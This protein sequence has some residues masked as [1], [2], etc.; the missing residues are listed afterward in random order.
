MDISHSNSRPLRETSVPFSYTVNDIRSWGD[1]ASF[2]A[3]LRAVNRGDVLNADYDAKTQIGSGVVSANGNL[4]NASFQLCNWKYCNAENRCSCQIGQ[5]GSMCFHTLAIAIKL[6]RLYEAKTGADRKSADSNL[7]TEIDL[8][9][10]TVLRDAKNGEPVSLVFVLPKN[11]TELMN[12]HKSVLLGIYLTPRLASPKSSPTAIIHIEKAI[13]LKRSLSLEHED[14][15]ML[16]LLEEMAEGSLTGE[17]RVNPSSLL[18]LL[19]YLGN[20]GRPIYQSD[21][22]DSPTKNKERHVVKSIQET[23]PIRIRTEADACETFI[24]CSFNPCLR[25]IDASIHADIPGAIPP[26]EITYI[27]P[28]GEKG[29]AMIHSTAETSGYAFELIP[30]KSILPIVFRQFYIKPIRIDPLHV[31]RFLKYERNTLQNSLPVK[32]DPEVESLSLTPLSPQFLLEV[33]IP[34][35]ETP[36][37]NGWRPSPGNLPNRLSICLKACYEP[38]PGKQ[39]AQTVVAGFPG[40]YFSI[41]D[42]NDSYHYFI[43]D[44]A[45]EQKG[46]EMLRSFEIPG[47]TDEHAATLLLEG[48]D[49]VLHFL[50]TTAP[51]IEAL[52]GWSVDFSPT[53]ALHKLV[54]SFERIGIEVKI[55][56]SNGDLPSVFSLTVAYKTVGRRHYV[57]EKEILE[58]AAENRTYLI[59]Y[60]PHKKEPRQRPVQPKIQI[61][62]SGIIQAFRDLEQECHAFRNPL[63]KAQTM[64]N[65]FAPFVV[66]RIR[67]L[68][69]SGVTFDTNASAWV[70]KY[71]RPFE[72]SESAKD[73]Q[74]IRRLLPRVLRP[75]QLEGVLWLRWLE[76]NNFGG[77]LADEMG[78]GKTLQALAWISMRRIY[79]P[80]TKRPV[81]VV[82]PTS[83][84]RNW[85]SEAHRFVPQLKTLVLS[86]TDR[87]DV[88]RLIPECDLVITS[89]ALLRR[90]VELYNTVLFSA[91]LL[92]EAQNIKNRDTD[93]ATSVKQIR[94]RTRIAITGTPIE[95]SLADLW[96]IF[97]FLMPGYLG[98]Y[99]EFHTRFEIPIGLRHSEAANPTD[100]READILLSKLR[101]KTAPFLLRRLKTTV[102]QDL[103]EKLEQIVPTE[104]TADQQKVYRSLQEQIGRKI[105]DSVS[106]NGF[107][108]SRMLILS[109]LLRLRQAAC[110]LSLLGNLNPYPN[111]EHPSGKLSQMLSILENTIASGHRVLIFSQFVEMLHLIR[112]ALDKRAIK[113]CYLDGTSKEEERLENVRQFN[114]NHKIPVFLI[115]LKAGGTGLTLTGADEVILF[116][117]WWNPAAEQQAIDRTH[118]IGQTRTVH[119][120]RLIT[121]GTVEEKVRL[122]QQR[123]SEIIAASIGTPDESAPSESEAI[124]KTDTETVNSLTWSDVQTLFDLPDAT[125]KPAPESHS[126]PHA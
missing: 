69:S 105:S 28:G 68:K 43:R 103:P 101:D 57:P 79:E 107:E 59:D 82:C 73:R 108:R 104:M 63:D 56:E 6:A 33:S 72:T 51:Q 116:D 30:L 112:D 89:Y 35:Q 67:R 3:A 91:C 2:N 39:P 54:Q 36:P 110:H 70:Q 20:L 125:P 102:A 17:C 81:L 111:S 74:E 75:Y 16:M 86:G 11:W 19:D 12:Q 22:I 115:S 7:P 52:L 38:F 97:D 25:S 55:N 4:V 48:Q 114:F 62:N 42:Q 32:I 66:N 88:F 117:P 84:V 60:G 21:I 119:A 71:L 124:T 94:A 27:V 9:K 46:L 76:R 126:D 58:A 123:K 41:P 26:Q 83:L 78:L 118:R 10:Q 49:Q 34:E 113:Y 13:L 18:W 100:I 65:G 92:D 95:N 31:Y 50:S 44:L 61:F 77:I 80:Q 90:D 15:M 53:P 120:I 98:T 1:Q 24:H 93:N 109:G 121:P 40:C 96:S 47:Q 106:E 29:Y 122:M 14:D 87:H 8:P 45:A 23:L 99:A 37:Q 85:E 64:S 5:S